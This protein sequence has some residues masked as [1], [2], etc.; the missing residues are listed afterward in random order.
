MGIIQGLTEFLPI[1]SSGHLVLFQYFFNNNT[2]MNSDISLEVFL[3]LGSLLAVIIYFRKDLI[4][5]LA[6]LFCWNKTI[7]SNKHLRKRM[8][9]LYLG[10]S[11]LVTGIVYLIFGNLIKGVFANPM[12]TAILL[13]AT[14][15]ILWASDMQKKNEIPISGMG[16]LRGIIIGI[17]QGIAML[18]GISR[19][20]TTI[21]T[22]LF[23]GLKRSE[24]ARF[25]F[26]LSIPAILLANI[27][28]IDAISGLTKYQMLSYVFGAL[29]AFV[30][31]YL[32]IGF[33]IRLIQAAKLKYFAF[34]C[35]FISILSI[36]LII[37]SH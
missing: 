21:A 28:E 34:Y 26:L 15:L 29:A 31:G 22:S 8:M 27:T 17:G 9:I 13:S 18:P 20:G 19:S 1:S 12:V 35:W 36:V 14:G 2:E 33:L 16:F 10:I 11:T 3:H 30:S 32:V 23:C 24:A 25:S 6:S 37:S 7:D 5:L 4:E